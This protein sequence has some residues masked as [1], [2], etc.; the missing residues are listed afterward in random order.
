ML[1]RNLDLQR[2]LSNG[3][4]LIVTRLFQNCVEARII[5]GVNIDTIV[6]IPRI[7]LTP[8]D[9]S[10]PFQLSRRQFPVRL[11]YSM[12]INK[13]Q[14]QTFDKVGI[15]LRRSCFS[16]GQLYVALSRAR[17]IADIKIQ[18]FNN[19]VQGQCR[20]EYFTPNVVYRQILS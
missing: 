15:F 9:T 20:G 18:V 19:T 8:S 16:H 17:R 13:A 11:A 5:T 2:G 6:F 10:L 12:T 14:G 7:H 4:R 3:T 1:L